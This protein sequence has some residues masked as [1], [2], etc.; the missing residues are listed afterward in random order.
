MMVQC[1]KVFWSYSVMLPQWHPTHYFYLFRLLPARSTSVL[2][3][4][5]LFPITDTARQCAPCRTTTEIRKSANTCN[6]QRAFSTLKNHF[7][8]KHMVSFESSRSLLFNSFNRMQIQ[9]IFP[10]KLFITRPW[11][12]LA[13]DKT[14]KTITLCK[15]R[16][17]CR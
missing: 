14:E 2:F 17:N 12:L 8:F 5:Q 16:P 13:D 4:S 6:I 15:S 7:I 1:V 3:A 10:C 9:T 11:H